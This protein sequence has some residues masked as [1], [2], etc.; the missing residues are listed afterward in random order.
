MEKQVSPPL[1]P[2][3]RAQNVGETDRS[4]PECKEKRRNVV[5]DDVGEGWWDLGQG[6]L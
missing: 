5:K 4:K 1:P 3:E 6:N 2:Q